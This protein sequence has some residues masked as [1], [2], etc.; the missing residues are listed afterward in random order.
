VA[1]NVVYW[2]PVILPFT[3]IID[4]RTGFLAFFIIVIIR[5]VANLI[6]NNLLTLEQAEVY[7]FRIP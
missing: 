2:I 7:P 6:R 3:T 1:Y 4:Y 5:A